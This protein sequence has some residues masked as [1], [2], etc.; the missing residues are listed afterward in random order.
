MV[1]ITLIIQTQGTA[2][3]P[4]FARLSYPNKIKQPRY[5]ESHSLG[6]HV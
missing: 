3:L 1:W 5:P 2:E 4:T 6:L